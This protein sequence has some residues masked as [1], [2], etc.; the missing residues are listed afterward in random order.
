MKNPLLTLGFA[1]IASLVHAQPDG[2][3]WQTT[4][5]GSE[6]DY[7]EGVCAR[8][9]SGWLI[10]GYSQSVEG[11]FAG[12]QGGDDMY[13]ASI[14][15]DGTLEG[16]Q[17]YGSTGFDRAESIIPVA[18]GGYA[19]IG[20][21]GE[22]DGDL[23]VDVTGSSDAWFG[24]LDESLNLVSQLGFGGNSLDEG[25]ALIQTSDGG[26]LLAGETIS[27]DDAFGP[28]LGSRDVFLIKLSS[29]LTTE[30]IRSYG[31]SS[32]DAVEDVLEVEDGFVVAGESQ[33]T[34]LDLEGNADG[35]KPWVFKVDVSGEVMWS[36]FFGS[37]Y[38]GGKINTVHATETGGLLLAGTTS[39]ESG[40]GARF[41]FVA[42]MSSDGVL[43]ELD[44]YG[45]PVDDY[46][47]DLVVLE[48]G[49]MVGVGYT[50]GSFTLGGIGGSDF[51]LLGVDADFAFGWQQVYGGSGA[52]GGYHI[53]QD[54]DG[55]LLV[56][57]SGT[58]D[59]DILTN[60]G[61]RD[62]T[63]LRVGEVV[64]VPGCMDQ[65]ACNFNALATEDDGSCEYVELHAILGE[66][67]PFSYEPYVY[68]YPGAAGSTLEWV[69]EGG[70]IT[71]GQ[72]TNEV[73]V[74]W[75]ETGMESL[76]VAETTEEGCLGE[77]V[78]LDIDVITEVTDIERRGI[79]VFPNP[80]RGLV[81]IRFIGSHNSAQSIQLRTLDGKLVKEVTLT[82]GTTMDC[83]WL[84]PGT[85]LIQCGDF[86]DRLLIV[87]SP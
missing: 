2:I 85:Y 56:G 69:A 72:G 6:M 77:V 62:V 27:S 47:E 86:V 49:S 58:P 26:F 30:W 59:G 43:L 68:S 23:N 45:T 34:D 79:R 61:L 16:I 20:R 11:P 51:W 35:Q 67:S 84:E 73:Y 24:M 32:I 60:N 10:C 83:G 54:A 70:A 81:Q 63:V 44:D 48:D 7:A 8:P 22:N 12:N 25:M 82:G 21:A 3:T 64:Q 71:E 53:L 50:Q 65:A 18:G 4:F 76:S 38:T 13:V 55:Y 39:F 9:Q 29:D 78:E 5:G 33:S 37:N 74:V 87:P 42:T 52:D 17:L 36:T 57:A 28:H 19:M 80:T 1:L 15:S 75:E 14:A 66:Q 40:Q 31:G 41:G 46:L